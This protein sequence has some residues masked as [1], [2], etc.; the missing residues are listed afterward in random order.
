MCIRDR[1]KDFVYKLH[2]APLAL[3]SYLQTVFLP[4]FDIQSARFSLT[5]LILVY[6]QLYPKWHTC[7]CIA[8]SFPKGTFVFQVSAKGHISEPGGHCALWKAPS[9]NTV[10]TKDSDPCGQSECKRHWTLCYIFLG[11]LPD[12]HHA[13]MQLKLS[14]KEHIFKHASVTCWEL[15]NSSQGSSNKSIGQLPWSCPSLEWRL[16]DEVGCSLLGNSDLYLRNIEKAS[17]YVI[18]LMQPTALEK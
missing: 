3:T 5:P 11:L 17:W 14:I 16:N 1:Y 6:L 13:Y 9:E 10:A 8:S 4:G 15:H 2:T 12:C 7:H 18:M